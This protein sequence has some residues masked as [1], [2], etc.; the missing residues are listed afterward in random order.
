[1]A[2]FSMPARLR[3]IEDFRVTDITTHRNG[4][5]GR[6]FYGVRFS[7]TLQGVF[8]PNMLAV[9]PKTALEG[10]PASDGLECYV[11]DLNGPTENMR[12]D[13]FMPLIRSAVASYEGEPSRR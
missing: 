5:G 4:I 7:C 3:G 1:M 9:V 6:R 8:K 13:S 12:G 2:S 11:I 10:A